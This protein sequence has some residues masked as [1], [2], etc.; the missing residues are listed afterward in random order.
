[1]KVDLKIDLSQIISALILAIALVNV[2]KIIAP[3]IQSLKPAR[4]APVGVGN[5]LNDGTEYGFCVDTTDGSIL[6]GPLPRTS[7]K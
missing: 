1:M 2:A 5:W 6:P 4:F 3:S 7:K